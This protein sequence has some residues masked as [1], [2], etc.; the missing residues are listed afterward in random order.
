MLLVEKRDIQKFFGLPVV[1]M[2]HLPEECYLNYEK[3]EWIIKITVRFQL[4]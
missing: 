1:V 3:R 2:I 4:C